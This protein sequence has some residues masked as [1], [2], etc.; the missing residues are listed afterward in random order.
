[1]NRKALMAI[2]MVGALLLVALVA[3]VCG[4]TLTDARLYVHSESADSTWCSWGGARYNEQYPWAVPRDKVNNDWYC[5][6][7]HEQAVAL[8]EA[9]N[10]SNVC[11]AL[12]VLVHTHTHMVYISFTTHTGV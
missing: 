9:R 11:R 12:N 3:T 8:Q 2:A 10:S 4:V 1:M 7:V 6:W 5:N